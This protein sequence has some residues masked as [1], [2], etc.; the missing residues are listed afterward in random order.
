[1]K[2]SKIPDIFEFQLNSFPLEKAVSGKREDNSTY[3]FSTLEIIEMADR[4]SS[5]LLK[6][7]LRKGDKISLISY[8][9]RPE[10]N[11]AD[12]GML[13]I[14][15]INVAVYPNI[16]PEEYVYIFNNAKIRYCITG[17]GDI[18]EKVIKAQK[19]IP[20]L[21]KIFTFDEPDIKKDHNGNKI[22]S[23]N[24]LLDSK[25]DK[26]KIEKVKSEFTEDDLATIIYTSGT[27][28]KP[29]G[30][31]LTHLNIVSNIKSISDVMLLEKGDSA[32]SYLPL[33]H[34][35]ERTM[36][37]CY[38]FKG[39]EVSYALSQNTLAEILKEVQP[40]VITAVPRVLEKFYEKIISN[41]KS[42]SRL[43]Q[44]IFFWAER[45]TQFY[46]FNAEYGWW[47]K[48]QKRIAD[49]FIFSGI[50]KIFGG[51]IKVMAV[52]ASACPQKVLKFFCS[53]GIPVREGY[54]LTETSAVLSVNRMP[55]S[56]A[57]LGTVGIVLPKFE[58]K[59]EG[60]NN[61]Y[62]EGEGEILVR[63]ES[64]TKGYY[65]D[66]ENTALAF[67]KDG[68]LMTGDL[69]ILIKNESGKEFIKLTNRIKE[70]LKSSN[71]KY[72]APVSIENRVKE[73]I[74]VAQVMVVGEQRKYVTALIVPEFE[75]LED[76]CKKVRVMHEDN[77]EITEIPAVRSMFQEIIN[78]ANTHLSHH[79]QIKKFILLKRNWTVESDEL[80]PTLK[81]K[82]K[83]IESNYAAETEKMYNQ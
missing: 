13:Q 21:E 4:F 23:W 26:D 79:E 36:V 71:G 34:G 29:K 66:P 72:L 65:N 8:N 54:G 61:I 27:T 9:N 76:W 28:G 18:L 3:S 60:N 31:M 67:N 50:R 16:S 63:G 59:I 5:G 25:P 42:S 37:Y 77:K 45:L 62:R 49:R 53:A 10:W 48:I 17:N 19:Y 22:E 14:G 33:C 1:M 40:H 57:M 73:S 12:L 46:D 43:R 39:I 20:S 80:T 68:W 55:E 7:G 35:F 32:L 74:Y 38:I 2:I 78:E 82:R 83:I 52:G 51:R 81:L 75:L 58:I 47:Y 41:V 56:G 69:G 15:V 24:V 44:A 11:I 64:V 70:L 6:S 30:V